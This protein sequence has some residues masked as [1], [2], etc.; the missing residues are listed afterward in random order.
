M[1]SD[2]AQRHLLVF[3]PDARGHAPE[4]I[5]HLLERLVRL[6]QDLTVSV[7]VPPDLAA[8]LA[9][10]SRH[11]G[12]PDVRMLP[13]S[14][15][16]M[17]LCSSGRLA[18]SGLA[19]WWTMRRR[20]RQT[21]ADHGLFLGFDHLTLPFGLG[22]GAGGAEI[23]GILFR[24]SVHY[25]AEPGREPPLSERLRDLH[26]AL[27]YPRMLRN[28]AV[29]TVWSLDPYFPAYALDRYDHGHKVRPAPDPAYPVR[30][31]ARADENAFA[32][33]A[34]P[35]RT[36][37][38]I[39]GVLSERKGM[40]ALVDALRR[41]EPRYA[42]S[43]AVLAAGMIDPALEKP[44][45]AALEELHEM[46]PEIWL[47]FDNRRLSMGEI[48]AHVANADVVL[49]PYQRFVGSSGV[50]LWAAGAGKPVIT[51]SYGLLG[52]LAR[53]YGLGL[54]I[55]T[56]DPSEIAGAIVTTLR[57]GPGSLADP[58]GMARFLESHSPDVFAAR[59]IEGGTG[60]SPPLD[61]LCEPLHARATD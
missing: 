48:A 18:V 13:L 9:G 1:K 49:A 7:L 29:R 17:K 31:T 24:P 39:F 15:L 26:K 51:Q 8:E 5:E 42:S 44:L 52:R 34:P 22:L 16:E 40:L 38:L 11:R 28:P 54:D 4:W 33:L 46:R 23:S 25:P 55:D 14:T 32:C 35:D 57:K 56:T 36:L 20:L 53:D 3:E 45:A 43:V 60:I 41:L 21:G 27:L 19:R 50:M 58:A 30:T 6:R 59:V 61:D 47:R 2:T 10:W 37:F 12:P